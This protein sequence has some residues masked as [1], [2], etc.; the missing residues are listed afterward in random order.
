MDLGWLY[1]MVWL[2]RYSTSIHRNPHVFLTLILPRTHKDNGHVHEFPLPPLPGKGFMTSGILV[3]NY[4]GVRIHH[5]KHVSNT[6]SFFLIWYYSLKFI[7]SLS[8][9][10]SQSSFTSNPLSFRH[11]ITSHYII[12]TLIASH[13]SFIHV[14]HLHSLSHPFSLSLSHQSSTVLLVTWDNTSLSHI[15]SHISFKHTRRKHT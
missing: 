4:Y 15:T 10:L 7:Q 3:I 14:S 6:A 11:T 9:W 8:S 12:D 13:A 5:P 2:E 1:I